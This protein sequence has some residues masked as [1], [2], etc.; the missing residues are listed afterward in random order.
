MI[1]A[2]AASACYPG[3]LR[4]GAL[5]P[6]GFTQRPSRNVPTR[7][8]IGIEPALGN[9]IVPGDADDVVALV[10]QGELQQ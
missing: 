7:M 1:T 10:D 3:V 2:F 5:G 6:D 4:T 8:K 9:D